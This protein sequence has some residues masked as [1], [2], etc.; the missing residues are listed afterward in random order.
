M[1]FTGLTEPLITWA[2]VMG[3]RG[4][5]IIYLHGVD[6]D[7]NAAIHEC[8]INLFCEEALAPNVSKW[9]VQNLVSCC[10]DNYNLQCAVL[11]QLSI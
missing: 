8:I 11:F 3:P 10:L 4:N 5:S 9:L 1:P 6:S 2:H 7:I